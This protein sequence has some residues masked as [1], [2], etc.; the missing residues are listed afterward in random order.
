M[1]FAYG[2]NSIVQCDHDYSS[3]WRLLTADWD[4]MGISCLS[5]MLGARGHQ[6]AMA[7]APLSRARCHES[8]CP[9]ELQMRTQGVAYD[10]SLMIASASTEL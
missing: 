3:K 4:Y 2:T 7:E 6:C 1:T 9:G 8:V 5:A 10:L